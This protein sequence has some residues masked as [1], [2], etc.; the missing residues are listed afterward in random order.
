M[1][2]T[3]DQE[4]DMQ[5]HAIVTRDGKRRLVE[6]ID[7]PGCQTFAEPNEDVAAVAA[8]A[9]IGW[10]EAWLVDE[11][12]GPPQPRRSVRAPG[13]GELLAV[14][15]P[16]VLAAR[17]ELRWARE[18]VGLSQAALA[19]RIGVSRQSVSKLERPGKDL[20]VGT[21][22]RVARALGL[23]VDVHLVER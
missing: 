22:E 8:D 11:D 18:A 14:R 4:Q 6:F 13:S 7:A 23:T 19:K 20:Q 1:A 10:L 21:L 5:Y 3:K 15:V 17:I 9:L 2:T 16:A 12:E